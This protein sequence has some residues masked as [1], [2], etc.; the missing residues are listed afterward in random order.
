MANPLVLD[1]APIPLSDA[2]V[3]ANRFLSQ[4]WID[5]FDQILLRLAAASVTIFSTSLTAQNA[6]IAATDLTD[7]TLGSG[8]YRVSY[9]FRVTQVAGVASSLQ[10]A[11]S[12]LDGLATVTFT[13]A[14]E[15][16][17]TT[18]TYQSATFPIHVDAGSPI[19]FTTTYASNPAGQMQHSLF[20]SLEAYTL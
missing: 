19:T 9:Y 5:W 7:G 4:P 8:L 2:V 11:I 10:I 14:A 15:A 1:S 17:N 6:S 20:I 16:G 12:W 13:G 3:E 18:S